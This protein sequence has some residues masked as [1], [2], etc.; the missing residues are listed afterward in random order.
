MWHRD[1]KWANDIGNYWPIVSLDTGLPQTF[2]S[3]KNTKKTL[4]LWNA[5]KWSTRR[6]AYNEN[7]QTIANHND[8]DGSLKHNTGWRNPGSKENAMYDPYTW[9]VQGTTVLEVKQRPPLKTEW[10]GR[11][12]WECWNFLIRCLWKLI[13]LYQYD[14]YFSGI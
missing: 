7:K 4:D 8:P 3:W 12:V 2:S 1:M 11:G 9:N 13:E 14:V 6:Y 5:M 10:F